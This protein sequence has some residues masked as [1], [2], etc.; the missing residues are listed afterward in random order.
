MTSSIQPSTPSTPQTDDIQAMQY[1]YGTAAPGAVP[2]ANFSFSPAH[3]NPGDLVSF[4]NTSTGSPNGYVW[5]FGDPGYPSYDVNPTHTFGS[6]GTYFVRLDAGNLNGTGTVSRTVI[7]GTGGSGGG[8]PGTGPSICTAN[9]T[10]LCLSASRFKVTAVYDAGD[11]RSGQARAIP[12]TANTG[13]FWFFDQSNV[14]VVTK[15][16]PFCANPYNSIWV[17]AAGLTNVEVTLTYTDTKNGTVVTKKNNLGTAFEPI[18]DTGA[19]K[20]CP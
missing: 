17:F 11:G 15:I 3:P 16:L 13:Y 19:F 6:S 10:T 2:T 8:G 14:E 18:Q 4:T 20:T 5:I 1:F 12:L 7:V 9:E